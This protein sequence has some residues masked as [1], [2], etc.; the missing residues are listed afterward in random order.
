MM[1]YRTSAFRILKRIVITATV[2]EM[3][4]VH[5]QYIVFQDPPTDRDLCN[6]ATA[7]SIPQAHN[8]AVSPSGSE[9]LSAT[10]AGYQ[11]WVSKIVL[12]GSSNGSYDLQPKVYN[13]L[14][15]LRNDF[16]NP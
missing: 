10:E 6:L 1:I 14:Q 15:I 12:S 11:E 13:A 9:S 8:L 16:Q 3:I 4:R 7:A 5:R 2:A